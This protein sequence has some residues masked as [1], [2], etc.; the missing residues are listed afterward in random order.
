MR[1]QILILGSQGLS[2]YKVVRIADIWVNVSNV[3]HFVDVKIHA[4]N[5]PLLGT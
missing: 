3:S 2:I 1:I 5:K 4:W